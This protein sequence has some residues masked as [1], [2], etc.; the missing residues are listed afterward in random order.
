MSI[1]DLF[2]GASITVISL[3]LF[4]LSVRGYFKRKNTKMIFVSL[5]FLIFLIKGIVLS[6]GIFSSE[7][8]VLNVSI[9]LWIFDLLI[10]VLLYVTSLKG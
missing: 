4:V 7:I 1:L 3:G 2:I 8:I 6:I 9:N 5:V 10:L